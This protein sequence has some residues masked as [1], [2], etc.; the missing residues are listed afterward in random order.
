MRIIIQ[1]CLSGILAL[2]F[3]E[4]GHYIT[5]KYYGKTIT[6]KSNISYI[7]IFNKLNIPIFRYVW[8]MPDGLTTKQR[9]IVAVAGFVF[10]FFMALILD[11]IN[12]KFGIIY[13]FVAVIHITLYKFYAGEY[14]DFNNI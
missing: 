4:F 1:I 5:A 13:T 6:F 7:K 2:I 10:E 9:R 8:Y 11:I 12:V 14:N 3:H